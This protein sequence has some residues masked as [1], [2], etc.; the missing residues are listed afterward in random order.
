MNAARPQ[1]D[2]A[3]VAIADGEPP[4][5]SLKHSDR[6]GRISRA[7]QLR[8]EGWRQREIAAALGVSRSTVSHW[9]ARAPRRGDG[10]RTGERA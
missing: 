1:E 3:D 4:Y 5:L 8:Q 9:L 6:Q 7:Q 2:D 10:T